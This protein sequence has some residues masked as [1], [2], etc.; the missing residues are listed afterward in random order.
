TC[1]SPSHCVGCKRRPERFRAHAPEL[2]KPLARRAGDE[3]PRRSSARTRSKTTAH[4]CTGGW[5]SVHRTDGVARRPTRARG[6]HEPSPRWD[7]VGQSVER[8]DRALWPPWE[9]EMRRPRVYMNLATV[10][11]LEHMMMPA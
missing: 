3:R 9:D 4:G 2:D 8:L 1:A 6:C 11:S 5:R 10:K 7:D